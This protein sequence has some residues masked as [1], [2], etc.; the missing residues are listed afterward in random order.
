MQK[1]FRAIHNLFYSRVVHKKDFEYTFP[2]L[3]FIAQR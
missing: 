3:R 1:Y 2:E